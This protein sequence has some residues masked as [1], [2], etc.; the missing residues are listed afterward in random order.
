[1]PAADAT[2]Q[3]ALRTF[4]HAHHTWLVNW[5]KRRLGCVHHAN[6]LAHDT[7]LKLVAKPST[8]THI[9]E[10]RAF[11][12]TVAHG[13]MVDQFRK[14]ALEQAYLDAIRHL[15]VSLAP[16]PEEHLAML[17]I[18]LQIDLLFRGL[19][20]NVRNAFLLSKLEGLTYPEIAMRLGI[21]LRTVETYMAEAL[22]HL[23]TVPRA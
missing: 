9:Q 2:P 8:L 23:L 12:S 1:M 17:E 15:P 11:L 20:P 3:Q 18:L 19:K 10:P 13:L 16:S 7:F 4:Y 5:L 22:R 14:S 21:S 6:D